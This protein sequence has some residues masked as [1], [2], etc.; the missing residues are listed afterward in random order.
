MA[1]TLIGWYP[2]MGD[3]GDFKQELDWTVIIRQVY[4]VLMTA[5]GTRQWQ[6]EFG[7]D[8]R[9][10]LFDNNDAIDNIKSEI[11][12]AFYWLPYIQLVNCD[13]TLEPMNGRA[14]FIC[15][16]DLLISWNN[17]TLPI[18]LVVPPTLSDIEA[19][20]IYKIGVMKGAN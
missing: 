10:Y 18:N 11:K 12:N 3:N 17:Q 16:C 13:V 2:E 20:F 7:C 4:T 8:I 6:P 14:G 15:K 5:K 9:K 19:G 1:S